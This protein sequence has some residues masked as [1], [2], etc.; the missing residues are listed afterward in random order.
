MNRTTQIRLER[1]EEAHLQ[2]ATPHRV[3]SSC[4]RFRMS[5]QA[6]LS[7]WNGLRRDWHTSR[8]EDGQ[9]F[10]MVVNGKSSPKVSGR[11]STAGKI[12]MAQP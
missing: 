12:A 9:S 7:S 5:R 8:L 1:L 6:T 2:S 10:T 3:L 4:P 11:Q